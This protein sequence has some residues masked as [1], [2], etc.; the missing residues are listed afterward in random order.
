V[1]IFSVEKFIASLWD[2]GFLDGCFGDS[3]SHVGDVDGIVGHCGEI[4]LLE[5]KPMKYAP[6]VGELWRKNAWSNPQRNGQSRLWGELASRGI[7]VLV[8]YGDAD[9]E[10]EPMKKTPR[11]LQMWRRFQK[12]PDP[13]KDASIEI[14][15]HVVRKWWQWAEE[16]NRDAVA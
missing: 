2:W 10:D 3:R 7:T 13:T 16:T 8:L 14:V 1:T 5:G 6:E 11:R 12:Q 15:R 9:S 4:L